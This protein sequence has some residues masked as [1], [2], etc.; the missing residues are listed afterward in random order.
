MLILSTFTSDYLQKPLQLLLEKFTPEPVDIKYINKNLIG[1]LL[2]LKSNLE[3]SKSYA[4]LFRIFDFIEPGSKVDEKKLTEHLD[5]IIKQ[6]TSLKHEKR[7]PFL[8]FLCP[9]PSSFYINSRLEVIEK[10]FVEKLNENKIHALTLADIQEKYAIA[11]FENPIEDDTHVPYSPKFYTI[12]ACS[13]ARKLHAIIQKSYKVIA[14]DCDNTLWTGVAADDGVEGIVFKEHNIL[15]QEYL[16]KQHEKGILI[17]LCSKN[18]KQTVLDVFNQNR[19]K[20]PLKIEHISEYKI[21]WEIKSKNIKELALQLNLFPDSFRFIDDNPT[22]IDDV[23]QIPGIS[24]ITMPQNLEDFRNNW[25]FDL[26]EHSVVTETDKKRTEFYKQ[27]EIK[28]ALAIRFHDPVE[29]LRSPELGQTIIISKIDSEEDVETIQRVSQLSG[30]TNQFNLFPE[31]K[32]KEINEINAIVKNVEREIFIGRIKDK[33]SAEDITAIAITSLNRNS[34]TINNFFVSCRV[35]RRGMEYE[36]LKHIAQF[37]QERGLKKIKLKFKKSEKNKPVSSFLNILSEQ[38][39]NDPI[40]RFLLNKTENYAWIQD[41]LK[42]LF[43]KLNICLDFNSLELNEKFILTLSTQKIIELDIDS[44]IRAGL[45]VSEGS[46]LQSNSAALAN[47]DKSEKYLLKL[48]QITDSLLLNDFSIENKSIQSIANLEDRVNLICNN[49]LGEEEKDKSLVARGLDSLKATELRYYL[50]ECDQVNISIPKLLCEKTTAVSLIE[51]IKEGKK[52]SEISF[53]IENL[54]N[55]TLPISLQE[56]R[57]FLAEQSERVTNSSK[58]HMIVT[59]SA[60]KLNINRLQSAYERAIQAKGCDVFGYYFTV[61]NGQLIKSYIPPEKR[62]INFYYEEVNDEFDLNAFIWGKTREPLSM[63]DSNDLIRIFV[64]KVNGKYYLIFHVHHAIFDAVSLKNFIDILSEKYQNQITSN[65]FEL[66]NFFPHIESVRRQKKKL[67]DPTFQAAA[68]SFWEN[69][70]SK[71]ETVT[72]LPYDQ[73]LLTFK[74]ATEQAAKRFT[75]SLPFEDL[76]ALKALAKSTEFTSFIVLNALFGLLIASYTF[77]K[78]VTLITATNGREGHPSFDKMVGFFVNLLIQQVDL[79]K[80]QSFGEYFK[81]VNE[82]FLAS[83]E[84]QDFPLD[85]KQEILPKLGIK[86]ILLSPGFIYQSYPLPQLK[87]DNEIAEL[88][89]EQIIY[90]KRETCRFGHFTLFAQENDQ[91]LTFVIEY[92]KDLFSTSFIEGFAKN[93]LHTIQNV[94]A[95]PSQSLHEISVVCDEER[96]LL[97]SLGQGPKLHYAEEDNLVNRFKCN[98]EKYPDHMALCYG[99]IRLTYKEVDQQS[100]NLAHTLIAAGVKKENYV[101]IFLEANHLFFIAE[102]ATLKI[103]AIFIPLSKENPNERLKLIINDAK[104]KFFIVDDNTKGLFDTDFQP[105]QLISINSTQSTNLGKELPRLVKSMEDT[106]CILYT[107]GS[108]GRPKGVILQEKGIFRVVESPKFVNVLPGDKIAQTANQAFDAAQLEC[109]L[110]WNNGASLVLFDKE[111]ILNTSSLQSKLIHEK[112]THMW[113]TA[114]LLNI[115]ANVKLDLFNS[116]KYLMVGGDVVYKD[117]IS[118]ILEFKKSLIVING[119]GPTET[120]IFALTY[121]FEKQTLNNFETSPIGTP[122]NNTTIQILTP[123]GTLTPFGGI[124]ELSIEG[125]GVGRGYLNLPELEKEKFIGDLE[126]RNYLTGDL[127]KYATKDPQIMFIGRANTQQVKINGNLVLLEEVRNCLSQHPNIK[128]VELLIINLDNTNRLVAFYTL[129]SP[130]EKLIKSPRTEFQNHLGKSL[131]AYMFPTFYIKI[132]DFVTNVNGKIDKEQFKK[133][134]STLNFERIPPKTPY[135]K[136]ILAIVKQTLSFFPINIEI[137]FF[138]VGCDSLLAWKI[139]NVLNIKFKPEFAKEFKEKFKEKFEL[140]LE[141]KGFEKKFENEFEKYLNEIIFSANNLKEKVEPELERKGF[142][143][144]FVDEFENYLNEK[145]FNAND[146]YAKKTIEGLEALLIQKL[147]DEVNIKFLRELRK[148]DSNLPAI[149]FI[150]PAGGG[151]SLFDPLIKQVTFNNICCGIEDPLLG[152]EFKKKSMQEMAQKY[153]SMIES[154]I[155][156]HFILGG[157]SFGGMLALEMAAQYEGK[158]ENQHLLEVILFDTWVVAYASDEIKNEL[159]KDVLVHCEKQRKKTTMPDMD[160]D[161][162]TIQSSL[163]QLC[164]WHQEI[165]FEFKPGKLL[166]TKVCLFKANKHDDKFATMNIETENNYLSHSISETHIKKYNIKSTHY[167]LL[168]NLKENHLAEY[169]TAHIEAIKPN[170]SS[171]KCQTVSKANQ[172]M[173]FNPLSQVNKYQFPLQIAQHRYKP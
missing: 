47:N 156:G 20:M 4:I 60:N 33:F 64:I 128:Q 109:W 72:T 170:K 158:S 153:L 1:E 150:H 58:F 99:E 112:I 168:E 65:F 167:D 106:F 42:F 2:N 97:I 135:G 38:T 93:F 51:F 76:L 160:D 127:V 157:Y 119:Y 75:F 115:L 90:D 80:N 132:D 137:D 113:L 77:Q 27:A 39:N 69:A 41:G 172:V 50:F 114:G 21:N 148:G 142:E 10:L 79:E 31:S 103:G 13:L 23:S 122:I 151:I 147:N 45:N 52:S 44:L 78:N 149:V 139:A 105:C 9:S 16:V 92:A 81:Q 129:D 124:G 14:V 48:K 59:F 3:E 84:F 7:L 116:L 126:K 163:K 120:S 88:E 134:E 30:K 131:P 55:Q 162:S 121:T 57:I 5:L 133:F 161:V 166:S 46:Q 86:D 19:S 15:L 61:K 40:S 169:F 173:L 68:Y 159:K 140:K 104:L 17:C 138:N 36:M 154:E 82:K 35:F 155:Q 110:A 98:V 18:E 26:D 111:T 146:I 12:L 71:I 101:G 83:Q 100:T 102:L 28:A 54:H 145:M 6:I 89:P 96:N 164:E 11:E 70:L 152:V 62:K 74:P 108:T 49:L 136:V 67:E 53:P 8:V 165:G 87:L 117:T 66:R 63:L 94:C 118:K 123:F 22:E 141:I 125:D 56:Q 130:N 85:K 25:A 95:N 29:Y 37:S 43:K 143:K 24:C 32:A 171:K 91:K 73:P 107:S 34:I 144:K